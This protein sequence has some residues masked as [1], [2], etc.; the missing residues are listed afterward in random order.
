LLTGNLDKV[1]KFLL[2]FSIKGLSD[3][4][5]DLLLLCVFK[6]SGLQSSRLSYDNNNW[7]T[8]HNCSRFIL[9]IRIKLFAIDSSE[10]DVKFGIFS[11][12]LRSSS[13]I[14]LASLLLNTVENF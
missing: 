1:Y 4:L 10:R 12:R 14:F 2:T 6:L 5:G 13:P 9:E 11:F 8:S 3:L 7:F